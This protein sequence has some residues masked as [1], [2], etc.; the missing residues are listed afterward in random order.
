MSAGRR[1]ASRAIGARMVQENTRHRQSP[2]PGLK[3]GQA[4]ERTRE[5]NQ[6]CVQRKTRYEGART[7]LGRAQMGGWAFPNA[8]VQMQI[9]K[10]MAGH[11]SR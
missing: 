9:A 2:N 6:P 3:R 4:I 5:L 1:P 8:R 11:A 7:P 10:I